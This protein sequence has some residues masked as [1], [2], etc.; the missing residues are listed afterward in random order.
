[1]SDPISG[2]LSDRAGIYDDEARSTAREVL[3]RVQADGVAWVRLAYPDQHGILRGKALRADALAGAFRSGLNMTSTLLLKD[4]SGRTVFPVWSEGGAG[5]GG[6]RLEG[7]GDVAIWP[8]PATFRMLSWAPGTAL[9]LCEARWTDGAEMPFCPRSTLRRA[10]AALAEDGMTLTCGLEVEFHVHRLLDPRLAHGDAGMPGRPPLT[11]GLERGHAYLAAEALDRLGEPLEAIA[12]ASAAMGLPPR[13]LEAEFGPSQVEMT[14]DPAGPLAQA[15]A[16]IL[17]RLAARE[18]CRRMGLHA[19]FMCRPGVPGA[20]PSG[21]HL[22]Q[23]VQGRDGRNLFMPEGEALTPEASGWIAGLLARAADGCLLGAPTV[24]GYKR[25]GPGTMAPDR[26]G[27][28]RGNKGAMI[29]GL[30]APGDPASRIENRVAESAANPYLFI[31]GQI[32]AGRDGVARGMEAPP[33]T[34][35]PYA[36]DGPALPGSLG[37][38]AEAFA[39]SA[40]WAGQLG[41]EAVRWLA[42][43]KRAEWRRHLSVVTEWEQAE[44][45]DLF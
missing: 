19:T 31:V 7:A 18:A 39:A 10:V 4:T 9:M 5:I 20:I 27:W 41:E 32:L 40:F 12:R 14:F 29:R 21:W 1:M 3:A 34:D 23:S 24:N 2:G 36:S 16:L 35:S 8:D 22:H 37:E 26:V 44:Y 11:E 45:Y 42:T 6:G 17:F 33:P 13:S 28:G 43:I 15:D 25:Y 30:T 38:A